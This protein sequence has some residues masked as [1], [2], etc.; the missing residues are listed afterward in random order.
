MDV[1][2]ACISVH[3]MHTW[4]LL[5][6]EECVRSPGTV[7]TKSYEP[8]CECWQLNLC[9]LE[10]QPAFVTT[11]LSFLLSN[12]VWI[13]RR[14]RLYSIFPRWHTVTQEAWVTLKLPT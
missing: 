10:E 14:G 9:P 8:P 11:E 3:H 12:L 7:F 4:C 13:F 5:R 6:L 2:P 1:L